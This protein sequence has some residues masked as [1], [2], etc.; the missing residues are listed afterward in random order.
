MTQA[1]VNGVNWRALVE[2][3]S[4]FPK[5]VMGSV[6]CGPG[7]AIGDRRQLAT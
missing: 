4:V 3:K 7:E 2:Q 6:W 1:E 5:Q